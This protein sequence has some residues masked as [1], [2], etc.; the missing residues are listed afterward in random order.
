MYVLISLQS[1]KP[2]MCLEKLASQF[3][4]WN[5]STVD[6]DDSTSLPLSKVICRKVYGE[7]G[8]PT[9]NFPACT[10]STMLDF[11]AVTVGLHGT[12]TP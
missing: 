9:D 1:H 6:C 8:S 12:E 4:K 10:S 2:F 5:F 11:R 7:Q 3:N